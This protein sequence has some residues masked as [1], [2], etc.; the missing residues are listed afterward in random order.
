MTELTIQSLGA[1]GDGIAEL[2]GNRI[3]VPY[4]L[5][6]DVVDAEVEETRGELTTILTPSPDRVDPACPHF[7]TCGGCALQHMSADAYLAWKRE[8]VVVALAARGIDVPVEACVPCE[9]Q[10]RRRATFAAMRT[11]KTVRFGFYEGRSHTIVP[12]ETCPILTPEI[13][14]ARTALAALVA[15]GLT[16]KGRASVQVTWTDQGLDVHV[17][18]GKPDLDLNLHQ[19]LAEAAEKADLARLAWDGEVLS[20]RRPPTVTLGGLPVTLPV[21]GFLQATAAGEQALLGRVEEALEGMSH[22]ADLFAGAGTFAL[23]LARSK[24]VHA[25]EGS[26][27][28]CAALQ[29]AVQRHGPDRGLKPLTV[30]RRDL[31]KRPL[32]TAELNR[33]DGV[34]VD[35]PRAGAKAQME[36]L[37]WSN[38]GAVASVSCSPASF[39]RDARQLID[40]GYELKSVMPVDQFL[41][42]PHIE[43]VGVFEKR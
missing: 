31:F 14:E 2:D 20:E 25:V 36:E 18:G 40:G 37:A 11:R 6:G 22:V 39:A 35:P 32:L 1:Q 41:W 29:R 28:Q 38:V 5:P 8:Q 24:S 16:R 17:T 4:T 26:Q 42:S 3:Y 9:P 19:E 33:F 34:V 7:G 21:G 10:T 23:P 30:E 13:E 15:P 27:V 43:L 12:L